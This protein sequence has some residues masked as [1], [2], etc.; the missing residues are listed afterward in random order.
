VGED[1]GAADLLVGV[2]GVDAQLHVELY[3]LIK[4]GG[5]GL[6]DEV[7]GLGSVVKGGSVD[8]LSALLVFLS[9]K[10]I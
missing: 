1:D 5:S 4:L 9:S 10:H 7:H 8:E 2:T 3:G 6:D